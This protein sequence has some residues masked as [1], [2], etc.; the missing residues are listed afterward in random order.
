MAKK[1]HRSNVARKSS[2]HSK[3]SRTEYKKIIERLERLENK[4][5]RLE[6]EN[7]ILKKSLHKEKIKEK[8]ER[9]VVIKQKKKVRAIRTQIPKYR[10]TEYREVK[11]EKRGKIKYIVART[12]KGK[13][14][15]YKKYNPKTYEDDIL[16]Y[17]QEKTFQKRSKE[18]NY[19][20]SYKYKSGTLLQ[21]RKYDK[22]NQK[23]KGVKDESR[24]SEYVIYIEGKLK[25]KG[26]WE[27]IARSS[28]AHSINYPKERAYREAEE[29][30]YSDSARMI[31]GDG[32][33]DESEG[34]Q[35]EFN[36]RIEITDVYISY[37]K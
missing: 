31:L 20:K 6:K 11:I 33:Y 2:Q 10:K 18:T 13:I 21:Y 5:A 8:K 22:E 34:K 3:I 36:N 4:N 26:R 19:G 32:H 7:I 35:L 24:F 16:Y 27:K 1:K 15:S 9:Q 37:R 14:K 29:T 17:R 30:F 12:Q 23:A 25:I 28:S